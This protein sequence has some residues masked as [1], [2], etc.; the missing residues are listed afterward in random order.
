MNA[1]LYLEIYKLNSLKIV[2]RS[3]KVDRSTKKSKKGHWTGVNGAHKYE[4]YSR[5]AN[6][7]AHSRMFM[8]HACVYTDS[9]PRKEGM[10]C[11]K[12]LL[13]T[14][15]QWERTNPY[16]FFFS[17][18]KIFDIA[19]FHLNKKKVKKIRNNS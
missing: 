18:L 1:L 8:A 9:S 17:I 3:D 4:R 12:C 14:A 19:L 15:L 7:I 5:N 6:I 11:Y 2:Q 13:Q 10:H 16:F